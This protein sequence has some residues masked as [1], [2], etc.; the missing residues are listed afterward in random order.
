MRPAAVCFSRARVKSLCKSV[1]S[2]Q[3]VA[4]PAVSASCCRFNRLCL[5]LLIWLSVS[6]LK[7][8]IKCKI[9]KREH[10][11]FNILLCI[12]KIKPT[13]QNYFEDKMKKRRKIIVY[14]LPDIQISSRIPHH[15][16]HVPLFFLIVPV[17]NDFSNFKAYQSGM[18]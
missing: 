1:S 6:S 3:L 15:S 4:H 16:C 2:P 18:V 7:M 14:M 12:M 8:C 5:L 11:I 9:L 17:F 13:P 10:P